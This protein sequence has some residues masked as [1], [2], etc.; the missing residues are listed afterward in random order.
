[1]TRI[2]PRHHDDT[3]ETLG[4]FFSLWV[5]LKIHKSATKNDAQPTEA[6][7]TSGLDPHYCHA[8]PKSSP[9]LKN[10]SNNID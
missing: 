2:L 10:H 9:T 4:N 7:M 8:P 6:T 5:P 1:M 3:K